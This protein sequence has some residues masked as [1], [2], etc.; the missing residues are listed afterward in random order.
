M[1]ELLSRKAGGE[2]WRILSQDTQQAGTDQGPW[3]FW[4]D[5]I[6]FPQQ[7]DE[8]FHLLFAARSSIQIPLFLQNAKCSHQKIKPNVLYWVQNSTFEEQSLHV[9]VS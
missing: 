7:P 1:V 5:P 4:T 6:F 9:S 2:Y 8:Y 3:I